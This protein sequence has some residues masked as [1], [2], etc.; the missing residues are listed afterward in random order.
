MEKRKLSKN[1]LRRVIITSIILAIFVALI[2]TFIVL[3][4]D[5]IYGLIKKDEETIKKIENLLHETG[6]WAWLVLL[7][8]MVLQVVL[9]VLPNGPFEMM[10]GL[11][12]G[13]P[14]GIILALVGTTLGTLA[15][16]L[17]VKLFGKG[18]AS[19]FVDLSD[20]NKYKLLK[21]RKRCLVMMF[22]LL[23]IPALPKDFLAFLVPFTKVKTWEYLIINLI[24]RAPTIIFSVL[25]GNSLKEGNFTVVIVLGVI[26]A[27]IGIICV[28]F[29]KKIIMLLDRKSKQDGASE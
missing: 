17:L 7:F 14:I 22:G 29:N 26:A 10:A 4:W 24:A 27:I 16:I 25:F 19:L 13:T 28:I 5:D 9:A 12:Y 1:D 8:F 20:G 6:S 18:F 3:F 15:V 21:D 2:V 11:M 23:L